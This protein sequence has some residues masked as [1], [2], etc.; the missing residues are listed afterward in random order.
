MTVIMTFVGLFVFIVSAFTQ[1]F[2]V[3]FRRLALFTITGVIIDSLLLGT[4]FAVSM[5]NMY[6]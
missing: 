3:A 5:I 6:H 4:A 1:S 2:K